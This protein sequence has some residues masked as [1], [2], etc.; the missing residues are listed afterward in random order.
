MSESLL[1]ISIVGLLAGFIFSMPIAGPISI[2]I[3]SNALKGR[4]RYCNQATIG[5]SFADF[6]YVFIAVFGL[7]N[8]YSWYKPV[9]PYV[10]LVGAIFLVSV[11]IKIFKTKVDL[12]HIDKSQLSGK[13]KKGRGGFWTGF[14]LNFLNPTLFLG[15]ITSSFFVLSLVTSLGFNTGGLDKNIGDNFKEINKIEGKSAQLKPEAPSYL[16]FDSV[17]LVNHNATEEEVAHFPKYFP[18]LLSFFYALFLSLGSIIWFYYLALLLSKFRH[19]INILIVNRIIQALGIVLCLF[20][21]FL[22]YKAICI[23]N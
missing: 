3:T 17:K 2:L 23:F 12:E 5:A 21:V 8:L 10:L 16:K 9:I 13:I 15:W 11:G 14:M 1:T 6:I 18:L 22:G 4:I 20:G 7:T 19:R